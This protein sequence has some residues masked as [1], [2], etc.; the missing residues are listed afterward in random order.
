F[1]DG[2]N[3][4]RDE[5][6]ELLR[7]RKTPRAREEEI[8][9]LRGVF[10]ALVGKFGE[11]LVHAAG[12]LDECRAQGF[13]K[14]LQLPPIRAGL[15]VVLALCWTRAVPVTGFTGKFAWSD[16]RDMQ[17]VV[18]A[19]SIGVEVFVCREEHL[20]KVIALAVECGWMDLKAVTLDTFLKQMS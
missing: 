6:L 18:C 19:T 12:V 15:G 5:V 8:T 2:L 4:W 3:K 16:S 13:D 17:H 1:K 7:S 11:Y 9:T 10:D 20:P 14:L